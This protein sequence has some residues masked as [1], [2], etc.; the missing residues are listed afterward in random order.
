MQDFAG[1]AAG[2]RAAEEQ[3][4]VADFLRFD[5]TA[6]RGAFGNDIENFGEAGNA[7]RGQSVDGTRGYCVDADIHRAEI[8]GEIAHAGF[9]RGLGGAHHVVIRHDFFRA[10][11]RQREDGAPAPPHERIRLS[12]QGN[13]RVRA[14]IVR[15]PETVAAGQVKIFLQFVLDGIGD[16]MHDKI[17]MMHHDAQLFK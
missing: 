3:A 16:G 6:Q 11:I 8:R 5:I 13:Q 12:G 4:G 17:Q 9:Q 1:D 15:N 7:A 14:D 2:P 10:V